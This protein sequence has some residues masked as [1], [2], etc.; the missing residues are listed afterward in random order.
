MIPISNFGALSP[1]TQEVLAR[2][3]HNRV[4]TDIIALDERQVAAM[5]DSGV[6]VSDD[7]GDGGLPR[8]VTIVTDCPSQVSDCIDH[9]PPANTSDYEEIYYEP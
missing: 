3:R 1:K 6:A 2:A 7:P 8:S 4:G 9:T 5:I